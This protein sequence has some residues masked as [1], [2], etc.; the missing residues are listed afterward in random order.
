[1]TKKRQTKAKAEAE[2]TMPPTN[3][4]RANDINDDDY[5]P[6]PHA[7]FHEDERLCKEMVARVASP[8]PLEIRPSSLCVGSGLFAAAGIDAGR[9]IYHAVPDLAA[10]DPGNESFCDWCFEDTKLGVSNAS[11]PKA[12]E[13]VKLCSAC[14]AA[15]FCSKVCWQ[16]IITV[17]DKPRSSRLTPRHRIARRWPGALTIRTS[18][19]CSRAHPR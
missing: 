17:R 1:M 13:N 10:V 18:A 8:F 14:K 15:R 19:R 2:A 7:G 6:A 11:S 4:A 9:E 5:V 16:I 3:D 12:G